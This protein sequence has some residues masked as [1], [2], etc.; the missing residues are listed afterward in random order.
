MEW[1]TSIVT[2]WPGAVF[3]SIFVLA[4]AYVVGRFFQ[5]LN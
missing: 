4:L 5:W 1:F 2:T 3:F